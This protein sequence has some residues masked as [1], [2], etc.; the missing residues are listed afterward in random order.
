MKSDTSVR[1]A[2]DREIKEFYHGIRL[3]EIQTAYG[4]FSGSECLA[5]AGIVKQ[6]SHFGTIF[7]DEA[8]QI[9][10]LDVRKDLGKNGPKAVLAMRSHLRS[11]GHEVYVQC[12]SA[13]FPSAT[14]LLK[15]LGFSPTGETEV[16]M[17][18]RELIE[19][20]KWQP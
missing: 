8:R 11:R 12:D 20:W 16:N 15:L 18:T 9:G 4:L 1:L 14:R 3:R 2:S 6:R 17:Q 10:F 5:M 13:S 7:E 19:V